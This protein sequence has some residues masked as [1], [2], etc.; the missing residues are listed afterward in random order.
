MVS[1][2]F[3]CFILDVGSAALESGRRFKLEF[4]RM[5]MSSRK[6]PQN[7]VQNRVQNLVQNLPKPSRTCHFFSKT[8]SKSLPNPSS[9]LPK[10]LVQGPLHPVGFRQRIPEVALFHGCT[11]EAWHLGVQRWPPGAISDVVK[12][13]VL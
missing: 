4:P 10:V 9:N 12:P 5:A 2:W 6:I 1:E 3:P 11:L 13:M 8:T 7:L